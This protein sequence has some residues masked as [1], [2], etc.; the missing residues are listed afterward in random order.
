VRVWR[1]PARQKDDLG[2]A[3]KPVAMTLVAVRIPTNDGISPV[4]L[5]PVV[6]GEDRGLKTV[7]MTQPA[8][9]VSQPAHP[10]PQK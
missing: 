8:Q 10:Q 6:S 5:T 7:P 2:K 3:I 4:A 9:P 1:T